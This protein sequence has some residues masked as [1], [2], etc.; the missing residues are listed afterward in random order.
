[1]LFSFKWIYPTVPGNVWKLYLKKIKGRKL[2]EW[3]HATFLIIWTSTF[4][5]KN[6]NLIV[7][8]ITKL[9]SFSKSLKKRNAIWC[10]ILDMKVF[11]TDI[12]DTVADEKKL[13][14]CF[15]Q[16]RRFDNFSGLS[17]K[18]S[19]EQW[20]DG[21]TQWRFTTLGFLVYFWS[22]ICQLGVLCRNPGR[23]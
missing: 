4:F 6:L 3:Y 1:M 10:A 15:I 9:I 2:F 17:Q 8:L 16:L 13:N 11:N 19:I 20:F 14:R 21:S 18:L 23:V 5:W 22:E 7:I 12:I